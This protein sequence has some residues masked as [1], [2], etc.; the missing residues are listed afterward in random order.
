M[1]Q[2]LAAVWYPASNMDP[3][4]VA[5]IGDSYA[6]LMK[7]LA[8]D[9][10]LAFLDAELAGRTSAATASTPS[11]AAERKAFFFLV[12]LIQLMENVWFEFGLE[13]NTNRDNPKNG[14][15]MAVFQ[16]WANA[17]SVT[18]TWQLSR[19]RYSTLFQQFIDNLQR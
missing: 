5:R 6:T 7:R 4:L 9:P 16:M 13:S 14:G 8:G 17:P 12:E 3:G 18:K 1:F 19:G 2:D 10:D 15:W 11:L